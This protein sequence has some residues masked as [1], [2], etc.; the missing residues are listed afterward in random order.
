MNSAQSIST[1]DE[2]RSLRGDSLLASVFFLVGLTIVQRFIG[3][4]RNIV[5]CGWLADDQLGRW[6]LA[7]NF[8]LLAAPL[9]VLG[10]PG[11]FGC[12][13]EYY[14]QRGQLQSSL[15]RTLLLT[16]GASLVGTSLL[17]V[18]SNWFAW[19]LYDNASQWGLIQLLGV[20][21]WPLWL[22]TFWSSC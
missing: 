16:V 2:P 3:F 17:V 11:S 5:F 12:Y 22:S 14:R 1:S 18:A 4:G 6:S 21:C 19:L 20:C 13:V 9:L 15:Q 8:L 10:V 7:F